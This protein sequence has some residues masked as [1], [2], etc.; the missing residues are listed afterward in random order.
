MRKN[1]VQFYRRVVPAEKAGRVGLRVCVDQ[2]HALAVLRRQDAGHVDGR[3][4]FSD[5]ALEIYDA[6]DFH[7]AQPPFAVAAASATH[8]RHTQTPM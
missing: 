4:G 3:G 5:A 2:Q 7:T 8:L 6:D 1:V